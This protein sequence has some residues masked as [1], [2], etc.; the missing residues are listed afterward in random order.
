[1]HNYK[2]I[3]LFTLVVLLASLGVNNSKNVATPVKAAS[4]MPINI[5]MAT[6]TK[7]ELLSY[8]ST[9]EGKKGDE[10]L[11]ELYTIIKDHNEY[12]YESS[13]HRYIFKIIDRNWEL[14]PLTPTQLKYFDYAGDMPYIRKLYAD[15]NDDITTADLFKN[16]DASRVSFDK[17]HIWAQSMGNFGRTGG[18]GSDFHAL[19]P[20]D[21]RGNQVAHSNYNFAVPTSGV[22]EV[23]NDKGT[24]VGRYGSIPG[25][26][27]KVFEPL[28]QYKGDIARAMLYMT[29]R[30]YEHIDILHPKLTLINGSP[31]AVTA[32][33]TQAGLAGDLKTLLEWNKFDPVDAYE[34]KRNDLIYNNYQENRNPFIDFPEWADII[35]DTNYSGDGVSF[36]DDEPV[37]DAT[38][39]SLSVTVK[40][41]E[42]FYLLDEVKKSSFIVTATYSDDTTRLIND[43]TISV[44]DTP[45]TT[46]NELG[47]ITLTFTYSE[48]SIVKTATLS[49]N[50]EKA[51]I[52]LTNISIT[53]KENQ[54]FYLF[55]QVNKDSF[56]VT[57]TYS[58]N[59]SHEV[60][61]FTITAN[62][63]N[64]LT[65]KTLGDIELVFSYSEGETV[66]LATL[67]VTV[68]P[69]ILHYVAGGVVVVGLLSLFYF[70]PTLRKKALKNAKKVVKKSA[71]KSKKKK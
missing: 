44:N 15:Y 65:Y 71:K 51:P 31:S 32:S 42:K 62:G 10:L 33:P 48:K 16:P 6:T 35:Y 45:Y 23:M 59:T 49:I 38:L 41:N 4:P 20:A 67:V 21:V 64:L 52:T 34:I 17:E 1:M 28:D 5:N 25:Q 11:G 63:E 69:A 18:A 58:D 50:V 2:K 47:D 36:S 3:K 43:F 7:E 46:F 12:D 8:Y 14:S 22:T 61:D 13:T 66:K 56:I 54:N 19:L 39:T 9:V 24:L 40:E 37:G 26:P 55:D 27:Q 29:A 30:Y 68:K 60:N 53:I 57:A 70:V